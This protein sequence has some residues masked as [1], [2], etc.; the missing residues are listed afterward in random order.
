[1]VLKNDWS[2]G[3][4]YTADDQNDVANE[5]N[6][7][8]DATNAGLQL[9]G[10]TSPGAQTTYNM[11][12][13]VFAWTVPQRKE[14]GALGVGT[15]VAPEDA[16]PKG[17]MESALSGLVDTNDPRLSDT[18]T[19]GDN[20]VTTAKIQN[21]AVTEAKLAPAVLANRPEIIVGTTPP[22]DTTAIWIDTN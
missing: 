17:Q 5:V 12:P 10:T 4:P 2:P 20:T 18:R 22:G 16:V 15:A 6:G 11:N 13:S 7:K 21:D 9:Y 14:G 3:D 8:V 1:M 19:P